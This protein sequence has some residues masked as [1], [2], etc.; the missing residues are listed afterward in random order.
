MTRVTARQLWV[1]V[2]SVHAVTY[3]AP[4]CRHARRDAGLKGFWA[5]Y[6]AARAAPLGPVEA[7]PVIAA[8]F[9][10]EPAMV[11]RVVP[12]CWDVIDPAQLTVD[13]AAA[14]SEALTE[15]GS[16]DA[17]AVLVGAVALLRRAAAN[18]D[19]A[20]R[21]M[22]GANRQLW[23]TVEAGLRGLD[24]TADQ[25]AV[26]EAW[27]ACTTLREH[28]GDG[29][30]AALVAHDLN[31]LEAH[32]LAAGSQGLSP[33]VLRDSRGWSA[34]QWEEGLARLAGRGL[35]RPDG[36]ATEDGQAARRSVESVT[37]EL[38]ERALAALDDEDVN[39][40]YRA[41]FSAAADIQRSGTLPFPNPMGLPELEGAPGSS[42][43][44]PECRE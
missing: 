11:R 7:G 15:L 10:F 6:F 5:G 20:G 4:A 40:L 8:F 44:G 1:A 22:T 25:M 9:N 31:G 16:T 3:F 19:G 21:I 29:H 30:V 18:C 26:A 23:P 2:E 28:R 34:S 32:L 13:R 12:A 38:S 42:N 37:D 24:L 41:L 27:Q 39:R 33:E 14:A 35:L 43:P 36:A 17:L